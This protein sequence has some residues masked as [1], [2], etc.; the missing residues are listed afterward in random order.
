M[1]VRIFTRETFSNKIEVPP[2]KFL[3]T[4]AKQQRQRCKGV[5][6]ANLKTY[7]DFDLVC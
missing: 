2:H 3:T 4:H 7:E 1:I 6:E 5:N